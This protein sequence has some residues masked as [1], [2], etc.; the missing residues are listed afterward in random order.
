[1]YSCDYVYPG[2]AKM[3]LS[4]K[5][6][7]SDGGD[8]RVLRLARDEARQDEGRSTASARA[9]SRS[10]DGSVVVRKDYKVLLDRRDEAA[11]PSSVFPPTP[12][13][14]VAINVGEPR[15]W[16]AGPARDATDAG[17]RVSRTVGRDEISAV[18]VDNPSRARTN[19]VHP[20]ATGVSSNPTSGHDDTGPGG[21]PAHR[22][23]TRPRVV[24]RPLT[25][26]R[27]AGADVGSHRRQSKCPSSSSSSSLVVAVRGHRARCSR[28]TSIGPTEVGLVTK[29]F[30]F[31]KLPRRQP[32]RLPRRGRLPGRSC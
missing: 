22:P 1:M 11:R 4:V 27:P 10:K 17:V 23:D 30:A 25:S 32:D 18:P 8:D 24:G 26:G 19:P 20:A 2:G 31:K 9:R 12:R 21:V 5:E 29:R 15:S 13:G 14:D 7:S 3:T 16:G 6:V 28:S